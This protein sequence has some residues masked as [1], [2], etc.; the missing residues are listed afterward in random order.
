MFLVAAVAAALAGALT[1][2]L[3]GLRHAM[4]LAG[5]RSHNQPAPGS[6]ASLLVS[7]FF[8]LALFAL[9]TAIAR[10]NSAADLV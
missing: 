4:L 10:R 1:Y 8:A 6:L 3:S 2:G 9:A 5:G 7:L